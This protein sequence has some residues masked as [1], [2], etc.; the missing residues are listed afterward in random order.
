M[1]PIPAALTAGLLLLA[2]AT[3]LAAQPR[4]QQIRAEMASVLLQS[5]RYDEAAREYSVLLAA[6]PGNSAYRLNFARALLWGRRPREAEAQ[7]RILIARNG[8]TQ[9]LEDMLLNARRQMEPSAGETAGWVRERPQSFEYRHLHARALAREQRHGEALAQYDAL[10][11]SRPSAPLYLERARVHAQR[12]DLDAAGHD[13][14]SSIRLGPSAGAYLLAGDISLGRGNY[15]A[16]RNAYW[17]ARRQSSE[18]DLAAAMGRLE[19]E[20]RPAVG[21]LPDV[22]GDA[23]GWRAGAQTVSDN[24]GATLVTSSVRRGTRRNG[25]DASLGATARWFRALPAPGALPAATAGASAGAFGLDAGISRAGGRGHWFWRARVRAGLLQHAASGASPEGGASG[26]LYYRSWGAGFDL[27]AAPAYPQL[28]TFSA[29]RPLT[30]TPQLRQQSSTL[31]IAGPLGPLD[32][33]ASH[34]GTSLSDGNLRSTVQALARIGVTRHMAMVYSGSSMSFAR[35]SDLYWSPRRY[36]AHGVGPE[37]SLRRFTGWSGR[38]RVIPGVAWSSEVDST[39][40]ASSSR[41]FQL[42]TSGAVGYRGAGWEAGAGAS[43]GRGRAGD[44]ER[45]DATLFMSVTP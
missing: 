12:G 37:L 33:A 35:G 27:D 7:F 41:A 38:L 6:S 3:R 42:A 43:F 20:E 5:R 2:H 23:R 31:S 26:V 18:V 16:A 9:Q 25:L 30:G 39:G 32:V 40:A 4:P 29:Y 14:A 28:L 11:A 8:S 15:A 21:L 24:L 45:F 36:T 19:R 44:Y 1:R 10:L 34:Q 17:A 22:Y 13:V